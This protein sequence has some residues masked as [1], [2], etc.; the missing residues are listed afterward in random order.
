MPISDELEALRKRGNVKAQAAGLADA[1]SKH[2][3]ANPE[4]LS[5]ERKEKSLKEKSALLDAQKNLRGGGTYAAGSDMGSLYRQLMREQ[6]EK[7]REAERNL[8]VYRAKYAGKGGRKDDDGGKEPEGEQGTAEEEEE[9]AE[10]SIHQE[11]VEMLPEHIVA[12]LKAKYETEDA[13]R[14]LSKALKEEAEGE[15]G[16]G[17]LAKLMDVEAEEKKDG[18]EEEVEAKKEE[19]MKVEPKEV[20]EEGE[21]SKKEEQ[22]EEPKEEQ[23]KEDEPKE[24]PKEG[25]KDE[26]EEELAP[27]LEVDLTG[28][29]RIGRTRQFYDARAK[30]L[31]DLVPPAL[32]S[33]RRRD[34]FLARVQ[35]R[36]GLNSDDA[37]NLLD[38][39]CGAG[40]DVAHFSRAGHRVL[41]ADWSATMLDMATT[42]APGAHY[43]A[44]DARSLP[45]ILAPKSVDGIWI[46]GGLSHLPKSDAGAALTGLRRAVREG[47]V[48]F[49][50]LPRGT[51]DDRGEGGE[52]FDVDE[53]LEP[54]EEDKK[55]SGGRDDSRRKLTSR[56]VPEEI[57]EMLEG[58][59]WSVAEV[60]EEEEE[61]GG[62]DRGGSSRKL[63]A[64]AAR[65]TENNE[66]EV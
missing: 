49:L 42:T 20:A 40:R 36:Q 25:P 35:L 58:A 56:Y 65:R 21:E 16:A 33:D 43:L 27:K 62:G 15:E 48:L 1:A 32:P 63:Y 19:E 30:E 12:A 24:E 50:T 39:G 37:V 64:F 23:P 29:D 59:G 9:D 51:D 28:V 14:A 22:E 3:F 13:A 44:I 60:G 18:E 4:T 5:Q 53:R 54:T 17:G 7:K 55:D 38:V 6:R 10:E 34:A 47:G 57:R 46:R 41:G 45:E 61:D 52:G 31:A 11:A 66:A 26:P 2:K 8:R